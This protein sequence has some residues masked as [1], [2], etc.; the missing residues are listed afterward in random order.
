LKKLISAAALALALAS[1]SFGA[2]NA[3][4]VTI[5][6]GATAIG[7]VTDGKAAT[8]FEGFF[9]ASLATAALNTSKATAFHL[10]NANPGTE[11]TGLQTILGTTTYSTTANDTTHAGSPVSW[12][13][14]AD[15]FLLKTGGGVLVAYFYNVS[16]DDLT[17]TYTQAPGK[18][19]GRGL[20]HTAD[21]TS[22]VVPAVPEPSTWAMMILGFCGVGFITYRR[23][24]QASALTAA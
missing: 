5:Y 7:T 20:S 8:T 4:T 10:A 21:F 3:S 18:D 17:L 6:D 22:S 1:I 14:T 15:Y 19:G 16:G 12:T 2:A 13:E 9:G 23:R 11:T 24:N